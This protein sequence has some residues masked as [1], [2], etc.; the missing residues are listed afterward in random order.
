MS[1]RGS[2]QQFFEALGV[3]KAPKVEFEPKTL[4]LSGAVGKTL[5]TSIEV[6]T[7]DRKVVYGWASCDQPWGEVGKTKLSGK[8]AT[9][10]ITIQIP[11]PRPPALEAPLNRVRNGKQN[12]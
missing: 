6:T 11:S 5:E 4:D 7:A 3:A 8:S 10:P 2:I 1:G 12:A 9:L